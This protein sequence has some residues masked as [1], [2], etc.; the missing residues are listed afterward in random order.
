MQILRTFFCSFTTAGSDIVWPSGMTVCKRSGTIRTNKVVCRLQHFRFK[1][2]L[3]D[4]CSRSQRTGVQVW[5]KKV[6]RQK[7]VLRFW[8]NRFI[9]ATTSTCLHWKYRKYLENILEQISESRA[10]SL[11]YWQYSNNKCKKHKANYT[12]LTKNAMLTYSRKLGRLRKTEGKK[13]RR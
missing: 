9:F 4:F 5:M 12:K 2:L 8:I 3:Q 13:E 10:W 7:F 6:L 1:F 11:F